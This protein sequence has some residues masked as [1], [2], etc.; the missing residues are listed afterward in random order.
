[1]WKETRNRN[2]LYEAKKEKIKEL[3]F[4]G[5]GVCTQTKTCVRRPNPMYAG[6]DLRTHAHGTCTQGYSKP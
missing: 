4:L 3:G 2:M 5:N 1:M 6:F